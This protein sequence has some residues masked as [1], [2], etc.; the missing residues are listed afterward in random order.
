M[1]V[2]ADVGEASAGSCGWTK[3][4]CWEDA[5]A[6]WPPTALSPPGSHQQFRMSCLMVL[7]FFFF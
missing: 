3:S 1:C 6:R 2:A 4:P 5:E 7:R